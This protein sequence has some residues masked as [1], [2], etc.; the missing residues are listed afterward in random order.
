MSR[1][2]TITPA[3]VDHVRKF[4]GEDGA[5]F[6]AE[7]KAEHGYYDAVFTD[8]PVPHPVHFHEGMQ[9]RNAMREHPDTGGWSAHDYDDSWVK[10]V[11]LCL[12]AKGPPAP[13][14]IELPSYT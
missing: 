8:G 12:E 5:K 10:V 11:E 6:F 14:T 1:Q 9:V 13:V 2:L 7:T 3:L 4:L